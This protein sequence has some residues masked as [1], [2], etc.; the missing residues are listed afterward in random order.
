MQV[1]IVIML[2]ADDSDDNTQN[3]G[4]FATRDA[5]DK[6]KAQLESDGL[7]CNIEEWAVQ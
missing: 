6:H 2:C 5:A 4:V 1:Y 7:E 3:A